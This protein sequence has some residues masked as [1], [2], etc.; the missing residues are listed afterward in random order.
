MTMTTRRRTAAA[1]VVAA[2][3]LTGCADQ[4]KKAAG[5]VQVPHAN[6][7]ALSMP[8][9][10]AFTDGMQIFQHKGDGLW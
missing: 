4:E 5:P 3:T 6:M 2:L 8:V 7:H 1:L 9:G 10:H